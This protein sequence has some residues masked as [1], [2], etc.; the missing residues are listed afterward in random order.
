MRF[1]GSELA[2]FC[3]KRYIGILNF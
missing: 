2:F 1:L 3:C